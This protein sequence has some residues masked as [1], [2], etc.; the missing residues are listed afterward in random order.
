M[1]TY[2][3]AAR[4]LAGGIL[5]AALAACGGGDGDTSDPATT[6]P[7]TTAP[8]ITAAPTAT[9]ATA[10]VRVT[11]TMTD[12]KIELSE[13]TFEPGVYM[14]AADQKGQSSHAITIAGPG[15]DNVSTPTVDPGG[16]THEVTV[17][18]QPGIYEIWC[19]VGDH[20]ARGMTTTITVAAK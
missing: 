6:P 2:R 14:F 20:R 7:A 5:L 9:P 12:F 19:P 1:R 18:L 13:T 4:L 15:V 8:A 16:A 11:A 10:A 3:Q 17:T